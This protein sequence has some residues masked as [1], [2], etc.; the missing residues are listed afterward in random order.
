MT[1]TWDNSTFSE[2]D[3]LPAGQY[4]IAVRSPASTT[5]PLLRGTSATVF[6]RPEPD[7]QT[8]LQAPCAQPFLFK[9]D[10]EE[11]T[12]VRKIVQGANR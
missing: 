12:A 9:S 8:L 7:G 4:L 5:I 3:D 2:P 10:G 11:A 1:V 6:P